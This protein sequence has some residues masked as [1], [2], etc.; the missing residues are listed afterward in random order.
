MADPLWDKAQLDPSVLAGKGGLRNALLQAFIAN[1]DTSA[2]TPELMQQWGISAADVAPA[3]TNPYSTMRQ[4]A[5]T[6]ASDR[7][8]TTA[9]MAARGLEYSG[10]N[11]AAQEHATAAGG[12]R[13]YQAQQGLQSTLGSVAQQ[14]TG[15]IQGAYQTLMGQAAT[16]P[17]IPAAP[18]APAAPVA[19]APAAPSLN[20]L[21]TPYVD[22][23][24]RETFTQP[25]PAPGPK[26]VAGA[27][28]AAQA[29]RGFVGHA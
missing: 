18:A 28:L 13:N 4:N 17:T 19:P 16:D 9:A 12:L 8:D 14:Y 2:L 23:G 29:K 20:G 21:G 25:P 10:A 26:I 5:D 1:G 6:L 3:A 27:Q 24:A 7:H 11:A 15:L 22:P